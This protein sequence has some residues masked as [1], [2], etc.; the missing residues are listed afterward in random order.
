M[1]LGT[2]VF[3]LDGTLVDTSAD[4][5]E[6]ANRQLAA[7]GLSGRLDPHVDAGV[8]GRGGKAMLRLGF[9]RSSVRFDEGDVDAAWPGFID[10]YEAVIA[11]ESRFFAGA[12]DAVAEL[13]GA[14]WRAAI[15]TNKPERLARLLLEALGASEAFHALIGAD[16]LPVRKPDPAPFHAAVRAAGGA[17]GQAVMIGDTLTDRRTAEAAEAPCVLMDLGTSADDLRALG[18]HAV[19]DD[20]AALAAVLEDLAAQGFRP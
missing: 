20:F 15:C 3:D 7:L 11:R 14:G 5:I 12:L 8:S 16:T 6:G 10:A 4:L 2:A 17:P 18:A 19:L 13:R 1:S 9:E